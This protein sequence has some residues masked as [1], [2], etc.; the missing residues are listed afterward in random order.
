MAKKSKKLSKGKKINP[1]K[2]LS[3]GQ[4]FR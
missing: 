4:K 3:M 1:T 2:P